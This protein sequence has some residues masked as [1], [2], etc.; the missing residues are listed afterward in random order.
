MHPSTPPSRA[1]FGRAVLPLCAGAALVAVP[2]ACRQILGTGRFDV[3]ADAGNAL[4]V[5]EPTVLP[6]RPSPAA[7]APEIEFVVVVYTETWGDTA[8]V[9]PDASLPGLNLDGRCGTPNCSEP[10]WANANPNQGA[11]GID[12]AVGRL[13]STVFRGQITAGDVGAANDGTRAYL[14]RVRHFN[15]GTNS[16]TAPEAGAERSLPARGARLQNGDHLAEI[17]EALFPFTDQHATD[18]VE[19]VPRE[20]GRHLIERRDAVAHQMLQHLTEVVAD[21]GPSA[22]QALVQDDAE[23]PDVRAPVDVRLPEALF[24]RHVGRGAEHRPGAGQVRRIPRLVVDRVELRDAEIEDLHL[25]P[26]VFGEAAPP[27]RPARAVPRARAFAAG[28]RRA[29]GPSR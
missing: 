11:S 8:P 25:A 9:T 12:N 7:P 18:Q 24:G 22:G 5:C 13:S 26:A 1:R 27:F 6:E 19:H 15:G 16:P 14:L 20:L 28:S 23:R 17:V 21:D 2:V 4:E 10:F 3:R 29:G